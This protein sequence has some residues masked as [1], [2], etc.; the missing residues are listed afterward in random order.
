MKE[1]MDHRIGEVKTEINASFR[2]CRL[3]TKRKKMVF[4]SQMLSQ[5]HCFDKIFTYKKLKFNYQGN[6]INLIYLG[7]YG[8]FPVSKI[9][10]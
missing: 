9:L 4:L 10:L 8:N 3:D 2:N 5:N 7:L 1:L 6:S